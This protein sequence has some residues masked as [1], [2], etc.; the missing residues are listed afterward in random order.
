M[1]Y[2]NVIGLIGVMAAW[3]TSPSAGANLITNGSFESPVIN[4]PFVI[5]ENL[6]GWTGGIGGIEV[7]ADGGGTFVARG[8]APGE[9]F[10][11]LDTTQ[12]SSMFQDVATTSGTV[13]ELTFAYAPRNSLPLRATPDSNDISVSWEGNQVAVLGGPSIPELFQQ[14]EWTIYS[15]QLVANSNTGL[16]RLQFEALGASDRLGGLLDRVS[17]I[18]VPEPSALVLGGVALGALCCWRSAT[19]RKSRDECGVPS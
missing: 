16:S 9:Q 14:E 11:E 5:F 4:T 18:P 1:I 2:H 8:I 17:L 3:G 10:V 13:Y 6:P 19:R 12:N 15:F 7:Q